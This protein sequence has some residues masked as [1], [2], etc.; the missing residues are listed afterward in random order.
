MA[1]AAAFAAGQADMVEQLLTALSGAL[2]DAQASPAAGYKQRSAARGGPPFP[3]T[4]LTRPGRFLPAGSCMRWTRTG[5]SW[6]ASPVAAWQEAPRWAH[7]RAA[8]PFT[9][10]PVIVIDF[11]HGRTWVFGRGRPFTMSWRPTSPTPLESAAPDVHTP[12][13]TLGDPR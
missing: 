11:A 6:P 13:P 8:E 2:I 1:E 3:A 10:R 12:P 7:D 4:R 9:M 5:S